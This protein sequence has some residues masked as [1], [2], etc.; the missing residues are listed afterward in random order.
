MTKTTNKDFELFQREFKRWQKL[1][2][3]T[4]YQVY[5]KFEESERQFASIAINQGDMVVTVR[6]NSKPSDVDKPHKNIKQSAK[7]EALHL[8]VGRVDQNG[9]YRFTS[10][11]EMYE[12]IEELVHRL[13]GLL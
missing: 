10:E 12:A 1:F 4:G 13:E 6:L 9:R 11:N 7:H 8:L 2:G 3:L 5:F